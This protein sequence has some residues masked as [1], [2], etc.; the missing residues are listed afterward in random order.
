MKEER[1][2]FHCVSTQLPLPAPW[3]RNNI[4][5]TITPCRQLTFPLPAKEHYFITFAF[6]Y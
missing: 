3:V 5:F 6:V 2:E 1:T 4:V